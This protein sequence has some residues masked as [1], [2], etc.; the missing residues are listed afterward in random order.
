MHHYFVWNQGVFNETKDLAKLVVRNAAY[1]ATAQLLI[2]N[3]THSGIFD[4]EVGVAQKCS[5]KIY[6]LLA[7]HFLISRPPAVMCPVLS[8]NGGDR[9]E[10]SA[11]AILFFLTFK[12]APS[13]HEAKMT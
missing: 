6:L 3:G 8:A 10:I 13:H 7:S 5:I 11:S 9:S 2:R 12:L 4:V 1:L